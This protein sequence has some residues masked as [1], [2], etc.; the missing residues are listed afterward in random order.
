MLPPNT[1]AV[2]GP[3]GTG[4]TTQV[5]KLA[6]E[7]AERHGAGRVLVASLTRGAARE[8]LER[9]L[10]VPARQ[11]GTLHAFACRALGLGEGQVAEVEHSPFRRRHLLEQL[12]CLRGA[13][14]PRER[15][16]ED[17]RELADGWERWKRRR[18]LLDFEDLLERAA[19][20]TAAAPGAPA[21]LILDEAQDC[22]ALELR[23]AARWGRRAERLVLVGDPDQAIYGFRG[24]DGSWLR[25]VPANRRTLLA[26]SFRLPRAV[27]RYATAWIAQVPGREPVGFL[28]RDAEGAVRRLEPGGARLKGLLPSV[29]RDLARGRSV[30]VLAACGYLVEGVARR[31]CRERR[32]WRA[33]LRRLLRCIGWGCAAAP[34]DGPPWV[35]VGTIHSAKGAEADVVYVLPDLSPAQWRR[36]VV[37][38]R[39]ELLRLFYVALTRAREEV[40]LVGA[41]GRRCISWPCR[42]T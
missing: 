1:W 28:P 10:A 40:V 3:P 26:R 19:E 18:G 36:W 39:D 33:S 20:E 30:M 31:L 37:G 8:V 16:P 41:A 17:V 4:K 24:A 12:A 38:E 2:H 11:V 34:C 9:G 14:V 21:V 27:H 29:R 7:A 35:T 5:A 25:E 23:L 15:W 42:A 13:L 22:S 6:R 32:G